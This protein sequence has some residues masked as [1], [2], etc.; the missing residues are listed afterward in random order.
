MPHRNQQTGRPSLRRSLLG[1]EPLE[2]RTLLSGS[3]TP[4]A[5]GVSVNSSSW[6]SGDILVQ[7]RSAQP[8]VVLA[9]TTVGQRLSSS[10]FYEIDLSKGVSVQQALAAYRA[11]PNVSVAEPDYTLTAQAT[12]NDPGFGQQWALQNTGQGGGTP[13]ADIHATQAWTVTTGSPGVVVAVLDTGVDYDHPDLYQNIW[14]NQLAIPASRMKNLVDVYHDGYIS[15]RDL[16]NPVNQGAGKITDLNHDGRIDAADIL[17]PMVKNSRGQDTGRGGWADGLSHDGSGY[18]N[19]LIGWNFSYNN[20]APYDDEGHGTHVSGIIGAVGNNG[21]GV[22]GIDWNVRLMPLKFLDSQGHGTI[23]QYIQALNFAVAHG[24][25]I[26]NNSWTGADPS[27]ALSAAIANA[28]A[29]GVIFVAAAGNDGSNNDLAPVYPANYSTSL[30]NVVSVA[31]TDNSGRLASFSNYGARSVTLAA[32][33]LNI[34]STARGGG[35]IQMSGTS[36]ATPEVSAVLALVWGQH[37]TWSYQQVIADVTGTVTKSAALQGK[38]STSGV[39]N[40]AAAVGTVSVTSTAPHVLSATGG[41]SAGALSS[42]RLNFDRAI[43]PS[44]LT[45][46]NL[47]LLG[48]HGKVALTSVVPVSGTSDRSFTVTFPKQ[49]AAGTYTLYVGS[50]AKDAAGNRLASYQAAFKVNASAPH[51]VSATGGPSAGTLSSIRLNFDRAIVPSTFTTANLTLLGPSGKVALSSVVPVSGTSDRSFT[52]TFPART[53]AGTYTLYV[54][55]NAKD[56]AG[57]TIAPYQ[58]AFKVT[59]SSAPHVVSATGGPSASALSSIRLNFDRAIV[60]STLTTANLTLLGP[61]GK[62]ALTS[63]VP[64]YGTSDRSFTVTFPKQTEVGTYTLYVGGNAKDAVGNT[65]APYQAAFRVTASSAPHVVSATGGPS[66]GALA[67]IRLNFDRAIVPSTLTTANLTLLGPHGKV[68]LT[69]VV[70]VYGTSDRSFTV[71]FPKQTAAGTYTLYV[72]SAAKDAAGH[73]LA[74]YQA[75]FKV[76][77]PTVTGTPSPATWTSSTPVAITPNGKAVSL[78]TISQGTR[79]GHVKVRLNITHPAVTDLVIH[80]Q[81]P[82]GTDVTLSQQMGGPSPN[83]INTTFDDD[84]SASIL[85]ASGPLTNGSYQPLDPLSALNGQSTRGTWKLWVEDRVGVHHGT[86]TNWSLVVTPE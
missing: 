50:A 25:K 6:A 71:T 57:N 79:I 9:G 42:I 65:I 78:L 55:G 38:V 11:N 58:V 14:I 76:T 17:A 18:A 1:L 4:L 26:V 3:P 21:V 66:A 51:V 32:P 10:N 13:G 80:L 22:A 27:Q 62:V 39:L 44:T 29:H 24:A 61:S 52:V 54:G 73:S 41:P 86:L 59:A 69:S 67:S 85:F 45:T 19:D 47:T 60:P 68:A 12:P 75:A 74:P 72:G 20:D 7:F 64:V 83:M 48:P 28:R 43:V 33:G 5:P 70:P 34:L 77:A 53:A 40:A 46:A 15:F 36:M 82:D 23:S 31:A 84:A 2:D 8:Q 16:N 37:P 35:Y 81:A 63:V 30:D 49:T 56:A